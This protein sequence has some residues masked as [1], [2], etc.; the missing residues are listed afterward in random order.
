MEGLVALAKVKVVSLVEKS[1]SL[2][3]YDMLVLYSVKRILG[4][5]PYRI[6][7]NFE[8]VAQRNTLEYHYFIKLSAENAAKVLSISDYLNTS[9]SRLFSLSPSLSLSLS[10]TLSLCFSLYISPSFH[11]PTLPPS[12]YYYFRYI[13]K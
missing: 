12:D 13:S 6:R 10:L 7:T 8:R 9:V 1:C 4:S 11:L 2:E 5:L 3:Q